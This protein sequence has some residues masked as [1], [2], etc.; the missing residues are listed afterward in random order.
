MHRRNGSESINL[1]PEDELQR[2]Q[3]LRLL[4]QKEGDKK[5]SPAASQSTFWIDLPDS[6]KHGRETKQPTSYLSPP[7]HIHEGG[8]RRSLS[9]I[10]LEEQF[11]HMRGKVQEVPI[12]RKQQTLDRARARSQDMRSRET[13]RTPPVIVNTRTPHPIPNHLSLS[14]IHPLE[15]ESFIRGVPIKDEPFH[16]E[17]VYRPEDEEYSYDVSGDGRRTE[18]ELEDRGRREVE[19]EGSQRARVELEAGRGRQRLGVELEAGRGRQRLGGE[20][21]AEVVPRI[22]RVQ[23]DGWP[24]RI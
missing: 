1:L 3:L 21:E 18:L 17:G 6:L 16:P 15:R 10:P 13:S 8:P 24:G 20:L 22:V 7:S 5:S 14:E 9:S 19:L 4:L 23:T 2:Q 12:D 11:S